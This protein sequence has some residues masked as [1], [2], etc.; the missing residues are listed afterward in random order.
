MGGHLPHPLASSASLGS[1]MA[2]D[3]GDLSDPPAR[4][5]SALVGPGVL[6]AANFKASLGISPGLPCLRWESISAV[7]GCAL[8]LGAARADSRRGPLLAVGMGQRGRDSGAVWPGML[9]RKHCL[10][11]TGGATVEV[12]LPTPQRQE[13][14]LPERP[15]PRLLQPPASLHPGCGGP[16]LLRPG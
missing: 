7:R 3:R 11:R 2:S 8:K 14:F 6:A 4:T 10:P 12:G 13:W 15:C 1:R 9:L 16:I 5:S